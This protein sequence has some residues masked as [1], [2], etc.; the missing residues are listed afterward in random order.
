MCPVRGSSQHRHYP[1]NETPPT[2][3]GPPNTGTP[4]APQPPSPSSTAVLRP[5]GPRT[6]PGVS[7]TACVALFPQPRQRSPGWA[8]RRR[9]AALGKAEASPRPTRPPRLRSAAR[10]VP[11][12][13]YPGSGSHAQSTPSGCR[14]P[15]RPADGRWRA[16]PRRTAAPNRPWLLGAGA[17][18]RPHRPSL[19]GPRPLR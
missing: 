4:L 13:R 17:E 16:L 6:S 8:A 11:G 2:A 19:E 7:N 5:L 1:K 18:P 14:R 10:P 3:P 12:R 9:R 15:E